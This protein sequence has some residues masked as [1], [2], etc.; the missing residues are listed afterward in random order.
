[1]RFTSSSGTIIAEIGGKDY[2]C[3]LLRRNVRIVLV[4][5]ADFSLSC[6]QDRCR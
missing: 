2:D 3:L 6:W 5:D 4:F 1:M